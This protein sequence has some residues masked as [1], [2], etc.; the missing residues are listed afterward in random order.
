MNSKSLRIAAA[1]VMAAVALGVAGPAASAA[2]AN[3]APAA[4]SVVTQAPQLTADQARQLLASPEL[5][6]ELGAEGRAAVQAVADGQASPGV[7]ASAASRAGKA[8]IDLIKKQGP[9]FFKKA[10]EA[11]KKGTSAFNKWVSDLP[12]WHPVRLAIAAGGTDVIEWVI[13]QLIG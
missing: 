10:V 9:A 2:E 6:A 12:W 8:I 13:E 3:R 7:A 5:S 1:T 11:A 4:Q